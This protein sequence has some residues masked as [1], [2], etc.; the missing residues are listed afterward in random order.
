MQYVT[1]SDSRRLHDTRKKSY[2]VIEGCRTVV[3]E[4][5][6]TVF[7]HKLWDSLPRDIQDA[8]SIGFL[9]RLMLEFLCNSYTS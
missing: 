2:F 4:K 7:G 9:K 1:V 3:R 6:L 5:S 8:H